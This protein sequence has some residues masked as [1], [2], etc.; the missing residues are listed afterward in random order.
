MLQLF[1]FCCY[2]LNKAPVFSWLIHELSAR[3]RGDPPDVERRGIAFGV[4]V[5]SG[6]GSYRVPPPPAGVEPR[7]VERP[8][9]GAA[10]GLGPGPFGA[11]GI[12]ER[13]LFA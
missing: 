13:L 8:V 4:G 2:C 7:V 1:D 12:A 3:L 10:F 5:G 9:V 6:S 11:V